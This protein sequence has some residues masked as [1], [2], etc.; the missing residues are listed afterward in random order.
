M[1][2]SEGKPLLTL[3][4][5]VQ[6][7]RQLLKHGAQADNVYKA[8]SK[9]IG[10][11]SSERPLDNPLP[12]F[13]TGD[14]GVGKSTLLK[15]MFSSSW[16]IL[17]IFF[18]AKPVTDVD[19]KTVGIIPYEIVTKEFGK[20][21]FYDFAGQP[22]FYASH[23]AVLENAVKT[24]RPIILYL[25][26]LRESEQKAVDSIVRWMTL[27]Q[28]Q[29][30]N[31]RDKA[32]VIVVGSHAD[33]LIGR[34]EVPYA[35]ESTFAPVFKSFSKLEFV[36]FIAM[37]CRFADTSEIKQVKKLI[38]KSSAILRSPETVSLSAHT[39]YIYILESFKCDLAVSLKEVE[40]RIHRDL[41]E[42]KC[43]RTRNLLSFI[44]STLL[45]IQKICDQLSKK[46]L[47]LYL[48]NKKTLG[49]SF[50][51]CDR[52]TLLSKVTGT[53]FAPESF[54][55]HCKLASSIGVVT[56]SKLS[57]EFKSYD[58]EMLVA[59]MSHLELCFEITDKEVLNI[60]REHEQ[61]QNMVVA[62]S[63]SLD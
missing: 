13:I 54:R 8:H 40:E 7:I 16:W 9:H 41:S 26:D 36:S 59:F 25:A 58:I 38:Q 21:I 42:V 10:K 62:I 33:V 61:T 52:A 53:V 34:S 43:E 22:E 50:I 55:Q 1:T 49:N 11:L 57:K 60:V 24:S 32:H 15:S 44:P 47:I 19:E 37:D 48:H 23:C 2:D 12:I 5:Q 18:G 27:V 3:N 6:I 51:I 45:H 4:I 56:F 39:F 17:K 30:T 28:N 35:K 63:S 20:V 31:L 29:C 46:G 14:G